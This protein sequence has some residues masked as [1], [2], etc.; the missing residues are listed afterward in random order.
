MLTIVNG[1]TADV[2]KQMQKVRRRERAREKG[3]RREG[4]RGGGRRRKNDVNN[5]TGTR[6]D[7]CRFGC[8]KCEQP[9][10][11]NQYPFSP[12]V[13]LFSSLLLSSVLPFFF[14]CTHIWVI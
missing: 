11:R 13:S 6:Y 14:Y 5:F 10:I 12:F 3:I 2:E 9:Y 7:Q 1:A 4:E 8:H